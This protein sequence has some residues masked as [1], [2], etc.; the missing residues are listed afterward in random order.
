MAIGVIIEVA[1][2]FWNKFWLFLFYILAIRVIMEIKHG[3]FHRR[4]S[5]GGLLTST[6]LKGMLFSDGARVAPWRLGD[7]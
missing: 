3:I 2:T 5:H 6:G 1:T 4:E 7:F